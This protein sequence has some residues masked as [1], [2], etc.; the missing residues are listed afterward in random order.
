ML[1]NDKYFPKTMSQGQFES[2][3]F[4][5]LPRIVIVCDISL[6]SFKLKRGMLFLTFIP[7]SRQL[8]L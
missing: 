2:E 7:T 4:T 8:V 1:I 3:L 5:K 6:S